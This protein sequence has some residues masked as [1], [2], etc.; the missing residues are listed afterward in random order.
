M[1][2]FVVQVLLVSSSLFYHLCSLC[3]TSMVS[4][5]GFYTKDNPQLFGWI[6]Q[7]VNPHFGKNLVPDCTADRYQRVSTDVLLWKHSKQY[8][9]LLK[10]GFPSS[11][12]RT[13]IDKEPDLRGWTVLCQTSLDS[14][15]F[16]NNMKRSCPTVYTMT[17]GWHFFS[18]SVITITIPDNVTTLRSFCSFL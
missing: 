7:G 5:T 2:F 13:S 10:T 11:L 3:F 1:F 4:L 15:C 18:F 8:C 12:W 14:L 16:E 6:L 17:D 9:T